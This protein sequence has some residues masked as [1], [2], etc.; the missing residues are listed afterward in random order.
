MEDKVFVSGLNKDGSAM[1]KKVWVKKGFMRKIKRFGKPGVQ[2]KIQSAKF[3]RMSNELKTMKKSKKGSAAPSGGNMQKA[4][5]KDKMANKADRLIE[6]KI[7]RIQDS[8][9]EKRI[10]EKIQEKISGSYTSG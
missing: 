8:K 1:K 3:S 7:E 10:D 4:S 5:K 9:D 6:K 2:E